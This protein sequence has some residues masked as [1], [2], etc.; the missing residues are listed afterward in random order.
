VLE[1][2]NIIRHI[3]V[4]TSIYELKERIMMTIILFRNQYENDLFFAMRGAGSSYAIATGLFISE[5]IFGKT[6]FYEFKGDCN[7]M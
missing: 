4:L 1:S 7:L 3:S 6:Q 5:N 2:K